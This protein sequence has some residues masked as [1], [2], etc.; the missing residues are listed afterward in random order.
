MKGIVELTVPNE[1]FSAIDYFLEKV[2]E[3]GEVTGVKITVSSYERT[4]QDPYIHQDKSWEG[5]SGKWVGEETTIGDKYYPPLI[6]FLLKLDNGE[7]IVKRI[8]YGKKVFEFG[9]NYNVVIDY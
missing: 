9:C 4:Q 2:E 7:A 1:R 3:L 6:Y 5:E 8:E